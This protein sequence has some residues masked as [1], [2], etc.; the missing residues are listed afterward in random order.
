MSKD[1]KN[2]AAAKPRKPKEPATS[3]LW[4]GAGALLGAVFIGLAWLKFDPELLNSIYQEEA[5]STVESQADATEMAATPTTKPDSTT[6][7]KVDFVFDNM[8]RNNITE[9]PQD[10]AQQNNSSPVPPP[11]PA[12]VA[13]LVVESEA[14]DAKDAKMAP[15]PAE[16][17]D[18][19]VAST[20]AKSQQRQTT[21]PQ[22]AV[23]AKSEGNSANVKKKSRAE[24][25]VKTAV[26][27]PKSKSGSARITTSTSPKRTNTESQARTKPN[28][29]KNT[30]DLAAKASTA[31]RVER[32][33]DKGNKSKATSRPTTDRSKPRPVVLQLG[34]FEKDTD[35]QQLKAR[36]A[37][38]GVETKTQKITTRDNKTVYRLRTAPYDNPKDLDE[39]KQLLNRHKV[40]SFV[41]R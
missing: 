39:T 5:V 11:L 20:V 15:A 29:Q 18:S 4:F 37:L 30:G 40:K 35:V 21:A 33:T 6:P 28:V 26:V 16:Q 24:V 32:N 17:Q 13:P 7:A 19:P 27:K 14:V 1:Y 12:V 3:F 31:T 22:S 10:S 41:V 38:L 36:M 9:L 25:G 8:L 2:R 23:A 34:A